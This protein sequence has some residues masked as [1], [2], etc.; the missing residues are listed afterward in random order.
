MVHDNVLPLGVRIKVY[1]MAYHCGV[2]DDEFAA[3]KQRVAGLEVVGRINGFRRDV[4]EPGD[5]PDCLHR[6]D[7]MIKRGRAA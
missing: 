1:D 5:T 4:I 7:L 3:N 2:R 6:P